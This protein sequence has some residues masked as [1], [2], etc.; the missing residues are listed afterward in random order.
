MENDL[1]NL[2]L[3]ELRNLNFWSYDLTY[4]ENIRLKNKQHFI[5]F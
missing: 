4:T 5:L 3:Y 2:F 1:Y